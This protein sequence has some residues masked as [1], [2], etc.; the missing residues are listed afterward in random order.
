MSL[1]TRLV[2]EAARRA[3]QDPRVRS[4]AAEL[5]GEAAR[6]ARPAVENAGRHIIETARET[7]TDGRFADDPL[8]YAR[9]FRAKLLPPDDKDGR[10]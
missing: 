6:R 3:A 5:A 2:A 4:K 1:L 8:G 10:G 9:R 7:S